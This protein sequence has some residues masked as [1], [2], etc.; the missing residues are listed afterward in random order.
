MGEFVDE[1]AKTLTYST[2]FDLLNN[3][4]RGNYFDKFKENVM[5]IKPQKKR[6]IK[7]NSRMYEKQKVGLEKLKN[8]L[9][10]NIAKYLFMDMKLRKLRILLIRFAL[11]NKN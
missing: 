3:I 2:G 8:V 7:R 10:E 6:R 1:Y 11:K 9:R 4:F 5:S